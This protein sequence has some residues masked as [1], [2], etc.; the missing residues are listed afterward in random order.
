MTALKRIIGNNIAS[1]FETN[2][3]ILPTFSENDCWKLYENL[4]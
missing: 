3:T 1:H 4:P 2:K